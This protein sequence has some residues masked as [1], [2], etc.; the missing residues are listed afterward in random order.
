MWPFDFINRKAPAT[1]PSAPLYWSWVAEKAIIMINDRHSDYPVPCDAALFVL[2]PEGPKQIRYVDLVTFLEQALLS[3]AKDK[4]G[5]PVI[6]IDL[7]NSRVIRI[8]MDFTDK[9][10]RLRLLNMEI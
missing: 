3:N 5:H 1:D 8:A 9:S 4:N 7:P 10:K 6:E 2:D